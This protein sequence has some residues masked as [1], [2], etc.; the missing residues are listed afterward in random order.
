MDHGPPD[1]VVP[2]P[3]FG[4]RNGSPLHSYHFTGPEPSPGAMTTCGI[5]AILDESSGEDQAADIADT[6]RPP[7]AGFA[8]YENI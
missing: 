8:R 6:R 1:Q 3:A 7:L 2:L 5:L 4:L